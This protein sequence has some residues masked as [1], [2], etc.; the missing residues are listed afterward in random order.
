MEKIKLEAKTR[1]LVGKKT[2][3]LRNDGMIPVVLYGQGK[4]G[5]NLTVNTKEF[6]RIYKIAGMSSLIDLS[7]DEKNSVKSIVKDVQ[8]HPVTEK[9]LHADLIK[10]KMDEKITAEI[11][12]NFIGESIAVKELEGNLI[13]SKDTVEVEC[14]PGDLVHNID[15]DISVLKTFDDAIYVKDLVIPTTI[16]IQDDAEEV[17]ALVTP[18]RSEEELEA[19][20]SEAAA[21]TE[22][23][24]IEKMESEAEA[25]KAAEAGETT[26]EKKEEK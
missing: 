3:Q 19:M 13:T 15:V 14:L 4:E 12:L 22:K 21:D 20:D 16:E 7:I 18:P 24:Q 26:E 10:V 6:N 8:K 5:T 9:I 23:A 25:E 17:V 2:K 1:E 11:P